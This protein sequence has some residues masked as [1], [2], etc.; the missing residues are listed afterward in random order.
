MQFQMLIYPV[1]DLSRRAASYEENGM[2]Y[3]LTAQTMDFFIH[4]YTPTEA[5]RHDIGRH[6]FWQAPL[7]AFHGRWL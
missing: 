7:P 2:G 3:L 4:C 6:H 5:E 1:T